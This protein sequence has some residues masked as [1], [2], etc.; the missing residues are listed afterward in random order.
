MD[1]NQP[2]ITPSMR[3]V[4]ILIASLDAPT[5]AVLLASMDDREAELVQ[6][7]ADS[8]GEIDA[9]E[10]ESVLNEFLSA[11]GRTSTNDNAIA[12]TIG[13]RADATDRFTFLREMPPHRLKSL[14]SAE[15]PQTIALVLAHLAADRAAE[16]LGSL[17][18]DTQRVVI[19][20]LLALDEADPAALV[21]VEQALEARIAA[22]LDRERHR[23]TGM[24]AVAGMLEQ[25]D[26]ATKQTILANLAGPEREP[27]PPA[28]SPAIEFVDLTNLSNDELTQAIAV[29]EPQL[30][31][32][33][34]AGAK[35]AFADRV[36][37]LMGAQDSK[38]LRRELDRLGPT[39][40][41]D[42]E[43][44]QRQWAR[45]AASIITERDGRP[46]GPHTLAAAA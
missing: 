34:L 17:E 44:A 27:A 15:H 9:A 25:A 43:W 5:A 2:P 32:L 41:S 13:P 7:L 30:L 29:A 8:L 16:L 26:D 20:R 14:L 12:G 6:R 36:L 24:A 42:V 35:P 22:Q 1:G 3:K 23:A 11:G 39:R 4:A 40:L 19:E 10:R 37:G 46:R 28:T 18:P 21:A 38:R 45:L 33:A 31:R